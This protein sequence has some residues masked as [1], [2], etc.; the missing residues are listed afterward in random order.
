MFVGLLYST[1]GN[2]AHEGLRVNHSE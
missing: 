1:K 2:A